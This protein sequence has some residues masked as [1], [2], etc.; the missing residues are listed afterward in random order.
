MSFA[1]FEGRALHPTGVLPVNILG[2]DDRMKAQAAPKVKQRI[3][4]SP[5]SPRWD[6]L[7]QQLKARGEVLLE[8]EEDAFLTATWKG[9]KPCQR[10]LPMGLSFLYGM[11]KLPR[12]W[13]QP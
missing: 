3:T 13:N 11:G 9:G 2:Y 12:F 8:G 6:V 5:A 7:A 4:L 10:L 1:G